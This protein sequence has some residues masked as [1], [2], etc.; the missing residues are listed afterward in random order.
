MKTS[1]SGIRYLGISAFL[2]SVLQWI[3]PAFVALGALRLAIGLGSLALAAGTAAAIR[4]FHQDLV[5]I[6]MLAFALLGATMNLFVIWQLR[7]LR[8]R[9]AA[10]WRVT[11]VSPQKLRSERLQIALSL[12]TYLLLISEVVLHLRLHHHV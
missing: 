9:P 4:G 2:F 11:P 7:R 3:C 10:Q 6:P 8:N 1:A 5:R 12:A